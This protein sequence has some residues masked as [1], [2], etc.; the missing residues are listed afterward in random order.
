MCNKAWLVHVRALVKEPMDSI[1]Y[2]FYWFFIH[3]SAEYQQCVCLLF[4]KLYVHSEHNEFVETPR[5][6]R[7]MSRRKRQNKSWTM[8]D[9]DWNVETD[10]CIWI[11]QM[12]ISMPNPNKINF[13][14][15]KTIRSTWLTVQCE[16]RKFE[17]IHLGRRASLAA[18]PM[19]QYIY[20]QLEQSKS[21]ICFLFVDWT[22]VCLFF[23][24]IFNARVCC[25]VY[26]LF[27]FSNIIGEN[28]NV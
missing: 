9:S 15:L 18:F 17:L 27:V 19:N 16:S 2:P 4:W 21:H 20:I 1:Q 7:A 28:Y 23:F 5:R 3:N 13:I 10:K 24:V 6:S 22:T 14:M 25:H 11:E 12:Q 26:Q 8:N